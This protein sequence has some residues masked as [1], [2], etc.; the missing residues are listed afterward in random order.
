M[1]SSLRRKLTIVSL[2]LYWPTLF[3]LAHIPVPQVVYKAH[4]SDKS[5]HFI[6]YLILAFLIW[7]SLN[8]DAKI[9]WGKT[10]VWLVLLMI[11]G[12]AAIDEL[13]QD[14]VGRS[15]DVMDFFADLAGG[16]TGLIIFTFLPFWP[17]FLFVTAI[18]IFLL[19]TVARTNLNTILPITN[20]L[21]HLFAYGIFT[22]LWL[23]YLHQI[24]QIKAPK[25]KWLIMA[26]VLPTTFML[27]AKLC[28]VILGRSFGMIDIII[29]E[30]AIA[31]VVA[32]YYLASL[33]F[34]PKQR[35]DMPF[36]N[37]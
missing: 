22:M 1:V 12:Y 19:T 20:I 6:A 16:I 9:S 4:V 33:L 34:R 24:L 30:T 32:V 7:F 13:L 37:S 2:L 35:N 15:C 3:I 18:I 27:A 31:T 5:L 10:V 17:A 36:K 23:R 8:P 14:Y 11:A 26:L 29:S 28:S 25:L 21:F